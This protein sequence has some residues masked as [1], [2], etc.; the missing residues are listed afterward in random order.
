MTTIRM[1]IQI[2]AKSNFYIHQLDVK[3]AYLHADMDYELYVKQPQGFVERD[4]AGNELVWL[5]NKSLYGLKQAGR[6]DEH[7]GKQSFCESP[8]LKP[9]FTPPSPSLSSQ[10]SALCRHTGSQFLQT[11]TDLC[12]LSVRSSY[13]CSMF[14][15]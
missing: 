14:I 11:N 7:E 15:L 1:L 5:L 2:A 10:C 12:P 9:D 13:K 8:D 4:G 3:S 6:T